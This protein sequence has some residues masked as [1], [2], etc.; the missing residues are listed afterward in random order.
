[1]GGVAFR[2]FAQRTTAL[3]AVEGIGIGATAGVGVAMLAELPPS[4]NVGAAAGLAY[5]GAF[6]FGVGTALAEALPEQADPLR[7]WGTFG[8][9][10]LGLT[11]G[12][13]VG[14]RNPGPVHARD[15]ALAT[16][17]TGFFAWQG[18]GWASVLEPAPGGRG[19]LIIAPAVAGAAV[20]ATSRFIDVPVDQTLAATSIGAWGG[21]I[22]ATVQGL[23]R[24][25]TLPGALVGSAIGV[26]VGAVAVS[27]ALRVPP[28]VV[29]FADL[30]GV[31]VGAASVIASTI[32]ARGDTDAARVA[33]LVGAGVGLAGG[34]ALGALVQSRSG[35]AGLANLR[36]PGQFSIGPMSVPGGQGVLVRLDGW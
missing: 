4:A 32:L 7:R 2:S 27:P 22:G 6:G 34:A 35:S 20:A 13:V 15:V 28:R 25:P 36:I 1:L 31:G 29:L 5:G 12:A 26:G 16:A 17:A 24:E 23:R 18:A 30:G 3:S 33:G 8:G 11:V 10:T 14:A 19:A 21:A 9:A